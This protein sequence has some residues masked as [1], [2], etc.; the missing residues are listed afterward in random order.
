[1]SGILQGSALGITAAVTLGL[2]FYFVRKNKEKAKTLFFSFL[3]VEARMVLAM[4]ADV[5]DFAT[6]MYTGMH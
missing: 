4:V 6:G 3:R 2:M 5:L 1:M